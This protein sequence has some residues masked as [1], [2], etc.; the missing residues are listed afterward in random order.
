MEFARV[1]GSKKHRNAQKRTKTHAKVQTGA[2]ALTSSSNTLGR[3]IISLIMISL[4]IIRMNIIKPIRLIK[5]S[6]RRAHFILFYFSGKFSYFVDKF[7][8]H[9][10]LLNI[11]F[12]Y[13]RERCN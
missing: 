1:F 8:K 7:K 10:N 5:E 2:L 12:K 4:I 3:D 6:L 11:L 9:K 13:I